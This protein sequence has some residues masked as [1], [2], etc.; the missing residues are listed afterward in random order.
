MNDNGYSQG[1]QGAGSSVLSFVLG[2][3]VGASIALLLAPETGADT[4]NRLRDVAKRVGQR[5]RHS[6][7]DLATDAR[8]AIEAGRQEF[9][10]SRSAV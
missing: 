1:A 8:E 7:D 2:A 4:R 5:V 9:Q 10:K 3:V 6:A